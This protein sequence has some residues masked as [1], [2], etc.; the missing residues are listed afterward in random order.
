MTLEQKIFLSPPPL[1]PA[2]PSLSLPLA[3]PQS[4]LWE[5]GWGG[6]KDGCFPKAALRAQH[7]SED[8]AEIVQRTQKSVG[9]ILLCKHEF[10]LIQRP[11]EVVIAQTCWWYVSDY[12]NFGEEKLPESTSNDKPTESLSGGGLTTLQSS[13]NKNFQSD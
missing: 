9:S 2:F 8:L 13:N 1:S 6:H 4:W 11:E 12:K 5:W 7:G 10:W 3:V